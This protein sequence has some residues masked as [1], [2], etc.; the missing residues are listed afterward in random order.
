VYIGKKMTPDF[1]AFL[2]KYSIYDILNERFSEEELRNAFFNPKTFEDISSEIGNLDP[3]I[4]QY[5]KPTVRPEEV[6]KI[7][8][9]QYEIIKSTTVN[10]DSLYQELVLFWSVLDQSGKTFSAVNTALFL[11]SNP[12]L[13]VL[14]L[15]FSVNN[16]SVHLQYGFQDADRNLGAIVEDTE[17]GLV[18]NSKVLEEYLITHP[19][20]PNLKILPGMILRHAEKGPEF[21]INLFN[22]ILETTQSLNFSTILVD[23]DAGLIHPFSVYA[24][25]KAT[26]IL[27]HVTESPG[28][29]QAVKKMFDPELGEFVPSLIQRKKVF[30]VLNRATDGY[31]VK[32]THELDAIIDGN[33]TEA[34]FKENPEIHRYVM[35]GSPY[36]TQPTDENY[37][38]FLQIANI[39]HPGLFKPV[40]GKKNTDKK[41][42]LFNKKPK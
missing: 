29:L 33:K 6:E 26:K 36:L 7:A 42:N 22:L 38:L 41:I 35:D 10:K 5:E 8:K 39:I 31:H 3:F 25:R 14:L 28:H 15:D 40:K 1:K 18:L 16:P 2:Y 4:K 37:M 32:F 19:V 9:G 30:P 11:A 20:Y 34:T 24:L 13:K 12:D 21:Y 27:L 23:I 17:E